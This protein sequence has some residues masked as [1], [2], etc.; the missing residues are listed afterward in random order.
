MIWFSVGIAVCFTPDGERMNSEAR[1]RDLKADTAVPNRVMEKS[2]MKA[3]R[4]V[5]CKDRRAYYLRP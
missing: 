3:V 4:I 2:E 1:E 5:I